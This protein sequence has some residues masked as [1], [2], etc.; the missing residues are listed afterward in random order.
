V[1]VE[2]EHI[3]STAVPALPAK[4]ILESI[5]YVFHGD[6]GEEGG[7]LFIKGPDSCRTH[8]LHV[9]ALDSRQW[10]NYLAFRDGLRSSETLRTAFS[11]LK[12]SLAAEFPED[13]LSY[14]DAKSP[15]IEDALR[16]R[17]V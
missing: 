13:R 12:K 3:G 7:L 15:F 17:Q 14:Q 16:D 2:V 5:E 8:H 11:E 9:V 1:P 10:R 4:P 6:Q